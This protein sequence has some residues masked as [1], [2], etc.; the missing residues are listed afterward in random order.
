MTARLS[1][2]GIEAGKDFV[3]KLVSHE[4]GRFSIETTVKLQSEHS[5]RSRRNR[6]LPKSN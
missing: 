2:V 5:F 6:P 4:H 3:L 1:G